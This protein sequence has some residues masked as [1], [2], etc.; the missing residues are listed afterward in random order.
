MAK[1][2]TQFETISKFVLIIITVTLGIF[3]SSL[4][5]KF[6]GDITKIFKAPAEKEFLSKEALD[7]ITKKI[8]DTKL[9]IN[10]LNEEKD[11]LSRTLLSANANYKSEKE[12]FD[13]W[14][15][16][17][18]TL[19]SPGQDTQ[20]LA[21]IKI[22]DEMRMIRDKWNAKLTEINLLIDKARIDQ[23][24]LE[25]NKQDLHKKANDKYR[26]AL[27]WYTLKI[28]LLRL[29]FA[30]PILILGVYLVMKFR[31]SKYNALVWGYALFA[32]Y[33]FFIGLVPYLPSYG[34]YVRYSVGIIITVVIGYYVIKQLSA[35]TERKR[36]ELSKSTQERAKEIKYDT[37]AKA[38]LAQTCP[39]CER[40]FII[41]Q[42]TTDK[43]PNF[44]IHCGLKLFG[45]CSKC[46][47]RNFVH[48]PFC[49][50]CGAEISIDKTV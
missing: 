45:K 40:N 24:K 14:I 10:N 36:E 4:G 5:D 29:L 1:S 32:L 13:A 7:S 46:N 33:V 8:D 11:R 28:F 34:G 17:R 49:S 47:Q 22:M 27:R 21:R 37:A 9:E 25:Q 39:S 50:A 41:V 42:N 2:A 31:K 6:L 18:K 35:Y 16:T 23:A 38:F 26:Q 30:L 3:L 43:D 44:C 15:K 48:F 20:V 12:L 19:G